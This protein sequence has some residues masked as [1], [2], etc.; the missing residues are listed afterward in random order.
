MQAPTS[1]IDGT[2]PD[3]LLDWKAGLQGPDNLTWYQ[4]GEQEEDAGDLHLYAHTTAA[5]GAEADQV[6]MA[7]S[8]P[9]GL[10][11]DTV[12]LDNHTCCFQHSADLVQ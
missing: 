4:I 5:A 12:R 1:T 7:Y 9:Q 2:I 8:M 10:C 11:G 3:R 6:V